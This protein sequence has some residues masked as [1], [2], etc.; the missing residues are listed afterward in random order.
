[1]VDI[2][3]TNRS[4]SELLFG[5]AGLDEDLAWRYRKEFGCQTVCVTSRHSDGSV[6]GGWKSLALHEE[7]IVYGD[8]IE[9]EV[10]ERFGTGDAFFAGFL[11][12]YI[13]GDIAFPLEFGSALCALAHTIEGDVA[14][15]SAAE[16]LNLLKHGCDLRVKR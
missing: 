6:R 10:V 11:H 8:Y 15:V 14:Q 7:E 3:V 13:E 5:S 9:F 4:V 12:G 1:M 16:V 2:L